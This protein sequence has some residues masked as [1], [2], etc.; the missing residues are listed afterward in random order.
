MSACG[1]APED[2]D[3]NAASAKQTPAAPVKQVK[4]MP[5]TSAPAQ[6]KKT[7]SEDDDRIPF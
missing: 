1:I 6:P 7:I 2:D 4:Q 5:A 3:G